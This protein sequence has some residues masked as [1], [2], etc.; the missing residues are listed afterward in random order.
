MCLFFLK[1]FCSCCFSGTCR[2]IK[3]SEF[4]LSLP[5]ARLFSSKCNPVAFLLCAE[6]TKP[7]K[8]EELIVLFK[9]AA[10]Y[11]PSFH[12]VCGVVVTEDQLHWAPLSH[13]TQS[14]HIYLPVILTER[15]LLILSTNQGFCFTWDNE[16]WFLLMNKQQFVTLSTCIFF[17]LGT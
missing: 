3:Y 2:S 9:D 10:F 11:K 14:K 13:L 7:S 8:T 12:G 4:L 16:L 6:D 1:Y 17:V 5:L 15:Y